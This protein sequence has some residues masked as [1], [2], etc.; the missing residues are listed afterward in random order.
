MS[1]TTTWQ[2]AAKQEL[3]LAREAREA[4]LEGRARVSA[5][6]ASGIAVREYLRLYENAGFTGNYYQLLLHFSE[7]PGL[8][9]DIRTISTHLWRR[10]DENYSLPGTIN[11]VTEAEE[12]I[13]FLT[14][15]INKLNDQR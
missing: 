7:L 11:L 2:D 15:K 14:E 5:R 8:P 1:M 13:Q 9:N 3:A 6:R 12:L 4:N 10:V